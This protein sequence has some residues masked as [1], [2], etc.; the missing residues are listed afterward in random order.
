[1]A[2]G[3]GI[4]LL[5]GYGP[6]CSVETMTDTLTKVERNRAKKKLETLMTYGDTLLREVDPIRQPSVVFDPASLKGLSL[7]KELEDHAQSRY[8]EAQI[9]GILKEH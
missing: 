2:D 6:Q 1:M 4:S 3:F 7:T 8:S 9:V 5:N